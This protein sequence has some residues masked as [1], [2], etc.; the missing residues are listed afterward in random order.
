LGFVGSVAVTELMSL[1][2]H[3]GGGCAASCFGGGVVLR[4]FWLLVSG[5]PAVVRKVRERYLVTSGDSVSFDVDRV[6]PKSA[7][8]VGDDV[9][10]GVLGLTTWGRWV[11][12]GS[13]ADAVSLSD[14]GEREYRLSSSNQVVPVDLTFKMGYTPAREWFAEH[15]G[16]RKVHHVRSDDARLGVGVWSVWVTTE[17]DPGSLGLVVRALRDVHANVRFDWC[18]VD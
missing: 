2:H 12:V 18:V 1:T 17:G 10:R 3:T 11:V 9:H 15:W 14:V 7:L 5:S 6:I 4:K 8:V 16:F 13:V